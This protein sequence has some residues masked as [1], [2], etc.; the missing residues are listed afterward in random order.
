M[1]EPTIHV[2]FP[3]APDAYPA[4]LH[5]HAQI[6]HFVFHALARRFG[7]RVV[8]SPWAAPLAP[9][10]RDVLVSFLPHPALAWWKRSVLIENSNFDVD[11]WRHAAF[12]RHGLDR[13]VDPVAGTEGWLRGQY[14]LAV[15]S[16][17]VAI[18]RIAA[19]DPQVA[20]C[21]DHMASLARVLSVHPHPIDKAVFSRGFAAA[22]PPD[23]PRMLVYH[24]GP[25]KNSAELIAT[26]R[27]L[28]LR[29]NS[30]FSVTAY[31]D[32]TRA[33]LMAFLRQHF[34]IVANTSFSETGPI[35]MIEYLVSGFAVFGH[36]DWWDG[37]GN[38]RFT[39]SYDPARMEGNRANL[40]HIFHEL[41]AAGIA[42]ERD[43]AR[44]AVLERTDNDWPALLAPVCAYVEALLE[45]DHPGRAA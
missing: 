40:R 3:M 2:S 29:E 16:N 20:D 43:R 9:E 5:W 38:A 45:S 10:G 34:L 6:S 33:D 41:G 17:D 24:A 26:L 30:D 36:D 31:V 18:R 15:L 12:R 14:A 8:F 27:A 19:R 11:K 44:A 35:N 22:P 28:D 42:A 1:R 13:P 39:W 32:K 37:A 23:K 21:Y 4:A 7:R 25:R